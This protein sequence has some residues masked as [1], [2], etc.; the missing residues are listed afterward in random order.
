[1]QEKK[2]KKMPAHKKIHCHPNCTHL[3]LPAN[4]KTQ[5]KGKVKRVQLPTL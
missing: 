3:P 5:P 1:M 2:Q 4:A